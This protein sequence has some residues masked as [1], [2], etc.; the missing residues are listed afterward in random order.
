VHRI[1]KTSL[2]LLLLLAGA[3]CGGA[4]RYVNPNT[5]LSVMRRVA[6]VPFEN[7][8]PDKLSGEKVQRIFLTEVLS[9]GAFEVVE[10]GQVLKALKAERLE[11]STLTADDIKRLGKALDAQ[12]LFLG[13]VVEF[14]EN[15]SGAVPTPQVTVQLRLVETESAATVW[16]VSRTRGG[17]TVTARLFGVGGKSATVVAEE[18]I[19]EELL[20]LTE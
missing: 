16:S 9:L 13:T 17:A 4:N 18:L 2:V 7:V 8:T 12:A 11:S 15:R 14:E 20:A 10:P 5:D 1:L 19:R 6:V 3:A